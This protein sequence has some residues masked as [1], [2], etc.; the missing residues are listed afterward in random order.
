MGLSVGFLK[1]SAAESAE[2]CSCV[3]FR[4]QRDEV[5][6]RCRVKPVMNRPDG[7]LHGCGWHLWELRPEA[8]DDLPDHALFFGGDNHP[9]SMRWPRYFTM[10][11]TEP[12]ADCQ[13]T[14]H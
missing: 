6:N 11:R 8:V 2:F 12:A 5:T 10:E 3:P 1:R 13:S 4:E 7:L 14:R 9:T